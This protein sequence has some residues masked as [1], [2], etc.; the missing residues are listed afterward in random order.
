LAENVYTGRE[1]AVDFVASET[2]DADEV[3]EIR[4][5]KIP[6]RAVPIH[7]EDSHAIIGYRHE[8]EPGFYRLYDL[9]GNVVGLQEKGLESPLIDPIDLICFVGGIFKV[10]SKGVVT[11]TT[12]L[13]TRVATTSAARLTTRALAAV[14]VGAMRATFKKLSARSLTF[15]ATSAAR[16]GVSGRYVPIHILHLALKYGKRSPDPQGVQGAFLYTIKMLKNG[17]EYV[18]EVVVREQDWT[19]LHFLYK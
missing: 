14:V 4:S 2:V 1:E 9:D 3:F 10:L 11:G 8:V 17:R 19:I 7:D 16:M 6:T 12:R 13:A 5:G 15:T 18:L